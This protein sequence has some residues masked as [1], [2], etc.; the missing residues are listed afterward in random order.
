MG[1][2]GLGEDRLEM[3]LHG[4]GGEVHLL[5]ERPG[6]GAVIEPYEQ[7]GLPR[8]QAGG[9]G[10]AVAAVGAR[11]GFDAHGDV[12]A[13]SARPQR[14]PGRGGEMDPCAGSV[15]IDAALDRQEVGGDVVGRSVNGVA[16]VLLQNRIFY[17]ALPALPALPGQAEKN[18][19]NRHAKTT[20]NHLNVE[21]RQ[22]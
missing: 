22:P 7:F 14:E 10:A 16:D 13:D 19:H 4:V 2:A 6:V 9:A 11:R 20:L 5:R 18:T 15:V 17:T 8:R 3:V 21:S 12:L 1:G